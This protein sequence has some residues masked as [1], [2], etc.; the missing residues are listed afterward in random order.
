MTARYA[1]RLRRPEHLKEAFPPRLLFVAGSPL[2]GGNLVYSRSTLPIYLVSRFPSALLP[3]HD[4]RLLWTSDISK[5]LPGKRDVSLP[6]ACGEA[7]EE[8]M[9]C[10]RLSAKP[11]VAPCHV[12]FAFVS[13]QEYL[14]AAVA[15]LDGNHSHLRVTDIRG[16]WVASD[17]AGVVDRIKE[18]AQS[19]LPNVQKSAIVWASGG[20][21]GG[22][23]IN[24]T[25]TRTDKEVMS[26]RREC[27][28]I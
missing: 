12:L 10:F 26:K 3:A 28:A 14:D 7:H 2:F 16:I 17:E 9:Q 1:L 4:A 21:E 11:I 13:T 23:K 6:V 24:R 18:I 25:A 8:S 20:V 5:T 15:Y 27:Q 19:Y 22:P